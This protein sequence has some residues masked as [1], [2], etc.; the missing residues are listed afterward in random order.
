MPGYST[1]LPIGPPAVVGSAGLFHFHSFLIHIH[2]RNSSSRYR[3]GSHLGTQRHQKQGSAIF[4]L[5]SLEAL[6]LFHQG[7][8]EAPE[9]V[10]YPSVSKGILGLPSWFPRGIG[11]I[12]Q[13]TSEA[14]EAAAYP[15]VSQGILAIPSLFSR[16]IGYLPPGHVKGTRSSSIPVDIRRYSSRG[17]PW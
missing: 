1:V 7:T 15:S 13:G 16:G 8:S 10:A 17:C 2:L 11:M 5:V 9:A 3:L 14:P 6:A 12:H 4:H